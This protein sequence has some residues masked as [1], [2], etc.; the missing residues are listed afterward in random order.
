MGGWRRAGGLRF[1]LSR[2]MWEGQ[3]VNDAT[4]YGVVIRHAAVAP[5]QAFWRVV[6]VHHLTP[7]ENRG[8]HHILIEVVD[9]EGRRVPGVPVRVRADG[10]E[11]VFSAQEDE[12][13][14][15]V[16]VPMDRWSI[17]EVEVSDAPSDRVIG[18]T[19]AHADEGRGNP[20]FRHSFLVVWQR[21]TAPVASLPEP[22]P[23]EEERAPSS[24]TTP[25]VVPTEAAPVAEVESVPTDEGE[26]PAEPAPGPSGVEALAPEVTSATESTAPSPTIHPLDAHPLDTFV[27]FVNADDPT[28]LA[29]FF[30]LMDDL[31]R[32]RVAFGFDTVEAAAAARKV[33]VVG[34]ADDAVR[35][36]LAA[37][38]AD[39][40]YLR[41]DGEALHQQWV[42]AFSE[43]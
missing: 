32:T 23:R 21:T 28:T 22:Q 40:H 5:G 31:M 34:E 24:E 11:K 38:G 7:E 14:P 18:L 42:E 8:G 6:R 10:Q 9:E 43:G 16:I 26:T 29:A 17:Y 20:A 15:A 2:R 25:A 36:R 27:L 12:R 3:P 13:Q 35:E 41:G 19:A 39:V 37:S 33:I 1:P 30:V 4:Q